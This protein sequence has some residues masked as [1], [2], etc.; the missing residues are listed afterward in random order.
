MPLDGEENS[1]ENKG[2]ITFNYASGG[3]EASNIGDALS[4]IFRELAKINERIDSVEISNRERS[5]RSASTARKLSPPISS[6]ANR[7]PCDSENLQSGSIGSNPYKTEDSDVDVFKNIQQ[8]FNSLKSSVEI[9]E[10]T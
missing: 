6:W 7:N 3:A 8:D 5:S 9:E 2:D 10:L 4:E 1:T